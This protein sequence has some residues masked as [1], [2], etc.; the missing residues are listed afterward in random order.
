MPLVLLAL[1]AGGLILLAWGFW[2]NARAIRRDITRR[3]SDIEAR[4]ESNAND[5]IDHIVKPNRP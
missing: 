3:Y 1:V 2:L 5:I 4:L